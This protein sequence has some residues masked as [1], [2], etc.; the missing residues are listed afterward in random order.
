MELPH[1]SLA[2][3]I[4]FNPTKQNETLVRRRLYFRLYDGWGK[5]GGWWGVVGAIKDLVSV[6]GT[7]NH[8]E[9][10]MEAAKASAREA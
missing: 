3:L 5:E 2:P 6:S 9:V 4:G 10:R 7:F 1:L 8:A